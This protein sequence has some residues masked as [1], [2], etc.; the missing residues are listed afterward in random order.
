MAQTII[1]QDGIILYKTSDSSYSVDMTV[2]GNLHLTN[3]LVLGTSGVTG[4]IRGGPEGLLIASS[5][6][7]LAAGD[8]VIEPADAEGTLTGNLYLGIGY[9]QWPDGTVTAQ[10]GMYLGASHASTLQYYNF[11]IGTETSDTLTASQLNLEYPDAQAGQSVA[12]PTVLYYCVGTDT[13]RTLGGGAAPS[14]SVAQTF[15]FQYN[16]IDVGFDS[17][18][19]FS[20]SQVY[21]PA[22]ANVTLTTTGLRQLTFATGGTYR[23]DIQG[24]VFNEDNVAQWFTFNTMFGVNL[25]LDIEQSVVGGNVSLQHYHNGQSQPDATFDAS[26]PTFNDTYIL[27]TAADKELYILM[28][29]YAEE[30]MAPYVA[31]GKITVV[32]TKLSDDAGP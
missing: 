1:V 12:G 15:Y 21:T 7:G 13:W 4:T 14:P 22:V 31:E 28:Y 27:Q 25:E 26:G 17:R 19:P 9:D 3:E 11:L 5:P 24:Q 32:I 10:P 29:V 23:I 20:A 16:Q 30:P 18:Y 2:N 6:S 8:I